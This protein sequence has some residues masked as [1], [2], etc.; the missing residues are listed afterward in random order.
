MS[1]NAFILV[2]STAER[3]KVKRTLDL[4]SSVKIWRYDMNNCFY[5]IS[6]STAKNISREFR[7]K[8]SG[9]H[10]R[11]IVCELKEG[12]NNGWLTPET[13]YLLRNKKL[14]KE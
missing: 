7:D 1:R 11:F 9:D 2:Y 12:G 14:K 6:D 13:W 4:I 10:G 3:E 5:L 8:Y